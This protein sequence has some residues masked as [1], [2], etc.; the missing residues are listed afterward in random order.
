MKSCVNWMMIQN[1][2]VSDVVIDYNISII[3]VGNE[4]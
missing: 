2:M 1:C 3:N 4:W